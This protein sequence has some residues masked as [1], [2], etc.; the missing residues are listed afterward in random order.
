MNDNGDF[1]ISRG[2]PFVL[3]DEEEYEKRTRGWYPAPLEIFRDL[4]G[5]PSGPP[6]GPYSKTLLPILGQY[7]GGWGSTIPDFAGAVQTL[8]GVKFVQSSDVVPLIGFS[9]EIDR[10]TPVFTP[11]GGWSFNVYARRRSNAVLG[12]CI[13]IDLIIGLSTG[14]PPGSP[15][16]QVV[17]EYQFG[18][19]GGG[20]TLVANTFTLYQRAMSALE[21]GAILLAMSNPLNQL[22]VQYV[23]RTNTGDGGTPQTYCE[24]DQLFFSHP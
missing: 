10:P 9:V 11:A 2:S 5:T 13:G 22:V 21:M 15:I 24:I 23:T 18:P 1:L 16:I 8:D 6:V 7:V 19:V 4:E 20:A 12:P 17:G 14:Y 3:S